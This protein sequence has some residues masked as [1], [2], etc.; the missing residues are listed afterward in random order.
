MK[1]LTII[2]LSFFAIDI[3]IPI[4]VFTKVKTET[5]STVII[6]IIKHFIS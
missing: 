2:Y 4:K 6:K 3:V 1:F 5:E